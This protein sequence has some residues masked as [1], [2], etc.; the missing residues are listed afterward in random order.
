MPM[1]Q[2]ADKL[3]LILQDINVYASCIGGLWYIDNSHVTNHHID[4]MNEYENVI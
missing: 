1:F 2:N 3:N 4:R